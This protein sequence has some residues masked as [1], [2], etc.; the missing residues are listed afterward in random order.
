MGPV[1][2]YQNLLSVASGGNTTVYF[3]LALVR[4]GEAGGVGGVSITPYSFFSSL[5]IHYH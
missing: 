3:F 1:L 4:R 2:T 5:G